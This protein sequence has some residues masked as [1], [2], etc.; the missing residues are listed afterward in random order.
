MLT[1]P[2]S[3][4]IRHGQVTQASPIRPTLLD[5]DLEPLRQRRR[6]SGDLLVTAVVSV[7]SPKASGSRVQAAPSNVWQLQSSIL[8]PFCSATLGLIH[9]CRASSLVLSMI[10][11]ARRI[12]LINSFPESV[13]AF[14]TKSY[15]VLSGDVTN[16][17]QRKTSLFW[18]ELYSPAL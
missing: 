18:N 8:S 2:A 16:Y 17:S 6:D 9:G 14:I 5:F 11:W 15:F 7:W 3:L 4:A 12:H 1:F 10:V 13:S